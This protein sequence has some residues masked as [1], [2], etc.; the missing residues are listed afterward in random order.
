LAAAKAGDSILGVFTVVSHANQVLVLQFRK[1]SSGSLGL[2]RIRFKLK[3]QIRIDNDNI[4]F[5]GF[6]LLSVML[7]VRINASL[8][9]AELGFGW[10]NSVQPTYSV[11]RAL[12]E[13]KSQT[14]ESMRSSHHLLIEGV[15]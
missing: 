7:D 15:F 2:A 8:Y 4:Q 1:A 5:D 13:L 11:G 12:I 3:D 10:D 9:K 14:L 6:D